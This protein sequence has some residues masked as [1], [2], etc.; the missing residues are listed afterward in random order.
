MATCYRHPD[1]ETG[2]S[3]GECERPICHDC[4]TV[5]PVGVR[6]PEHAGQRRGVGLRMPAG[7][8]SGTRGDAAPLVVPVLIGLNIFVFGVNLVQGASLGENGGAL[9]V[10]WLLFGPLVAAGDWWRIVTA[11][12]LHGSLLHLGM[13]MLMLWW[14]GSPMEAALGRARFVALYFASALA[15]SAGALVW[16]PTA[17]TVGASGAIFGI[18]GAALV[19]ERQ[20]HYVLG[21]SALTIVVLNLV[22]TFAVPNI[23]IGGHVGGL[24][25]GAL[26]GLAL[27][28]FGRGHAAYGT[29]GLV[30]IAG[31]VGVALLSLAVAYWRVQPYA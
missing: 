16:T 22:F 3:C 24:A 23:S 27:S 1:R 21:G 31:I 19:F 30:G 4:M 25:G 15:G 28:R 9:F 8:R 12:F 7:L 10:D 26:A 5:T 11:A 18:L 6:C 20:R 13:N 17:P 14:I 29:P 2:L